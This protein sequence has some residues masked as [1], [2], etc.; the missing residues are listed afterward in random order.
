MKS[1]KV[2][3]PKSVF[4]KIP[5][6]FR[7]VSKDPKNDIV[8]WGHLVIEESNRIICFAVHDGENSHFKE[9]NLLKKDYTFSEID[10]CDYIIQ[11]SRGIFNM[12]NENLEKK[13]TYEASQAE[14]D[15]ANSKIEGEK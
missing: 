15:Y 11:V 4:K 3:K 2:R 6:F 7:A 8:Y 1:N 10:Y 9:R 14:L 13:F 12:N 5:H